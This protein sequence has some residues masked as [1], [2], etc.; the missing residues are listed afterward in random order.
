MSLQSPPHPTSLT[1][2][3][4]GLFM[5]DDAILTPCCFLGFVHDRRCNSIYHEALLLLET[6]QL[7]HDTLLLHQRLE[8][9]D[10]QKLEVV[11]LQDEVSTLESTYAIIEEAIEA[12][13]MVRKSMDVAREELKNFK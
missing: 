6:M 4:W 2:S 10:Q 11:K 5:I 3:F 13:A 8:A 7:Y 12:L 1:I 9:I